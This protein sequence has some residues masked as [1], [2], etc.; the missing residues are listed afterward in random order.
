MAGYQPTLNIVPN[1]LGII[2]L[3]RY[4]WQKTNR[5]AREWIE[6]LYYSSSFA[7][8]LILYSE[9]HTVQMA[10]RDIIV[11]IIVSS[12]PKLKGQSIWR[13][14]MRYLNPPDRGFVTMLL[15][16][17]SARKSFIRKIFRREKFEES[18][19]EKRGIVAVVEPPL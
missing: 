8:G 5:I 2:R 16:I 9:K 1:D 17:P 3:A 4:Q 7:D 19:P 6:F 11:T 15:D 12:E 14:R 18:I 13:Y 10:M